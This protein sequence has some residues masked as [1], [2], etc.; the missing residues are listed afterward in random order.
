MQVRALE[1][2][3]DNLCVREPGDLFEMPDDALSDNRTPEQKDAD[4]KVGRK[5]EPPH[6][7]EAVD[8]EGRPLHKGKTPL[9]RQRQAAADATLSELQRAQAGD[10]S[11]QGLSTQ[12]LPGQGP[13]SPGK[14]GQPTLE[15]PDTKYP[16]GKSGKDLV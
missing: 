14:T 1:K 8:A 11:R 3:F 7:F 12:P 10:T 9:E 13:R 16:T 4:A 6:W 15:S 5:W 2:G